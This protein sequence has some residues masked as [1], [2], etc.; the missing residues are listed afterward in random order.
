MITIEERKKERWQMLHKYY[1]A[2]D[3]H[4]ENKII[5]MWSIGE[6]L[7]WDKAKTHATF[8]YLKGE[9]LLKS[10]TL[11]GGSTIT[12]WGVKEV[13]EAMEGRETG[14]FPSNIVVI[15]NSPGANVVAGSSNTVSQ[16][17]LTIQGSV[18]D[19]LIEVLNQV[20]TPLPNEAED[21]I[22]ASLEGNPNQLEIAN[23]A[24]ALAEVGPS[25]KEA[26][27]SFVTSVGSGLLVEAIKFGIGV[28]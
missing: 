13:E 5:N 8:D 20:N 28:K 10:V 27:K 2:T 24:S 15:T 17:N 11:G 9:G 23:K 16:N 6:Q 14:H 12:H 1:E 19:R 7:G 21:L 4:G 22:K 26:L 25:W 18:T 3:G